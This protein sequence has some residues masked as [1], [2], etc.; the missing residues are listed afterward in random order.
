MNKSETNTKE[1]Y[2]TPSVTDIKPVSIVKG[3]GTSPGADDG[4]TE[5]EDE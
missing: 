5:W 2:E 4:D 1:P 3:Q